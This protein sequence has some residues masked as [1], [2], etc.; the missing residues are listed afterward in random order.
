MFLPHPEKLVD[1]P[2]FVF[3]ESLAGLVTMKPWIWPKAREM[4]L[5]SHLTTGEIQ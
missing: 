4:Q 3:V 1:N 2:A 5:F